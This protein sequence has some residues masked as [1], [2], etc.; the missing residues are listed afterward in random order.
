MKLNQFTGTYTKYSV[1]P[2]FLRTKGYKRNKFKPGECYFRSFF[3][4]QD[5][6]DWLQFVKCSDPVVHRSHRSTEIR[7]SYWEVLLVRN[8]LRNKIINLSL[9]QDSKQLMKKVFLDS[10]VW[11][12]ES[13]M[14]IQI[15]D[16]K[17]LFLGSLVRISESNRLFL[18]SLVRFNVE[19]KLFL[20]SLFETTSQN[21]WFL[22]HF[23]KEK[24]WNWATCFEPIVSLPISANCC[25]QNRNTV[26]CRNKPEFAR[27][28]P[29]RGLIPAFFPFSRVINSRPNI[30]ETVYKI[31]K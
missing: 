1:Y 23:P 9:I 16:P 15:S 17:T 20:D 7:R 26:I 22:V 11:I 8:R 12:K 24:Q 30:T 28:R 25:W 27:I 2:F 31:I 29:K 19:K 4:W 21:F 13:R 6:L 10:L 14:V 3:L 5:G 18:D